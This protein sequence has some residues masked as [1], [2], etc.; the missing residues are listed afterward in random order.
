MTLL[1]KNNHH[2]VLSKKQNSSKEKQPSNTNS[3]YVTDLNIKCEATKR[4]EDN[5]EKNLGGL[6]FCHEFLHTTSEAQLTK[7]KPVSWTTLK[8]GSSAP[9]K[10]LWRE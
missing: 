1:R 2:G 10:I 9:R 7:E 5:T 6:W 8:L 4:L 3:K